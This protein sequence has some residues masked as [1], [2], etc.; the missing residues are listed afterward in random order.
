MNKEITIGDQI[1]A[2]G[3]NEGILFIAVVTEVR[4]KAVKVDYCWESCWNKGVTVFTYCTWVPKSV[5][6]EKDFSFTV[7]KWFIRN[8]TANKVVYIKK[9]F[10]GEG[11][12]KVMV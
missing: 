3:R 9:Y 2:D 6:S 10:I 5:I 11:G 1:I 8:L 4:E 12:K 7:S